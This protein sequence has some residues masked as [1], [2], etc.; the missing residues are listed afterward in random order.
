[1]SHSTMP[2]DLERFKVALSKYTEVT[3]VNLKTNQQ[4]S[5]FEELPFFRVFKYNPKKKEVLDIL[6]TSIE[7]AY[8]EFISIR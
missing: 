4:V 7:E 6:V 8:R 2:M 1:M 5:V 3:G